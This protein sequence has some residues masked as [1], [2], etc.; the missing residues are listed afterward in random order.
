MNLLIIGGT[1]Y[2]GTD[3]VELALEAGHKV[4]IC[5]R[6]N[7]RPAFWERVTHVA[8]DRTDPVAFAKA[9]QGKSFDAV[10]DNIAYNAHEVGNA[11]GVFEGN[12]GRYI[13]TTSS[14]VYLGSGPFDDSMSEE[15]LN[16]DKTISLLSDDQFYPWMEG[17]ANGKVQAERVLFEQDAV[18]YTILRP[19]S[20]SGPEDTT[21]IGIFYMQRL[22]DGGPVILTNGGKQPYQPIYRLDLARAFMLALN[23]DKAINQ[24]YNIAQS[25][26]CRMIDWV[27]L[28]ANFLGVSANR[29]GVPSE[30]IKKAAFKYAEP[31][32][33]NEVKQD[34]TKA[35]AELNFTPT[36][37]ESWTQTTAQWYRDTN[38]KEDSPGY[39]DRNKEV[40]FAKEYPTLKI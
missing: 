37:I 29:V 34:T 40:A 33:D 32:T 30:W 19:P 15:D 14:A 18:P 6:G 36:P 12:I 1:S 16:L 31:F 27:E 2:F 4:S 11:L 9:L 39:A 26:A 35:S 8:V 5:S 17:Y 3:I 38:H 25:Q 21:R 22:L 13:L 20:V 10:I 28:A 23:S 7:T 24:A